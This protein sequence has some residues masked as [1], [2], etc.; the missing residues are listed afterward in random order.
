MAY[1]KGEAR[2]LERARVPSQSAF[3]PRKKGASAPSFLSTERA[4]RV[5]RVDLI[6][7]SQR[8]SERTTATIST[9]A[10]HATALETDTDSFITAGL[11]ILPSVRPGD[12]LIILEPQPSSPYP[13]SPSRAPLA[14][15]SPRGSR[16]EP[17]SP[18][19]RN[20]RGTVDSRL[21]RHSR[22]SA[23]KKGAEWRP[24]RHE[25]GR[26]KGGSWIGARRDKVGSEIQLIRPLS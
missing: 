18:N 26:G 20:I 13:R 21:E 6:Y 22:P 7:L 16:D 4:G 1:L 23:S 24:R 2:Y 12:P 14:L 9:S 11:F 3:V 17:A 19:R 8:A 15:N 10:V 5:F 25:G